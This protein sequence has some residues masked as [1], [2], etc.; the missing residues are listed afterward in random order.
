MCSYLSKTT[1]VYN[2]FE[3]HLNDYSYGPY[4]LID[5]KK[6]LVCNR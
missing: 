2:N 4:G 6:N 5:K 1:R 3:M